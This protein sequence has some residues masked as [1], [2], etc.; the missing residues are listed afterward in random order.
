[1]FGWFK[2]SEAAIISDE[3]RKL[4]EVIDILF[5]PAEIKVDEDGTKYYIDYSLDSN[6]QNALSDL[7]DGHNDK[8]TQNTVRHV[9]DALFKIRDALDELRELPS[10]VNFY[11]THYKD[12]DDFIG[13]PDY[14]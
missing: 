7:E 1:M 11:A 2:K 8:A 6:L 14:D 13:E 4:R 3:Q 9:V 10:D 5:P 12:E